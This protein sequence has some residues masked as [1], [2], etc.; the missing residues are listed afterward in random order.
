MFTENL[1]VVYREF[2]CLQRIH[3][4]SYCFIDSHLSCVH[5]VSL[6]SPHSIVSLYPRFFTLLFLKG[7]DAV[8]HFAVIHMLSWKVPCILM[9][10]E[11]SRS[12]AAP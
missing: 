6:M 12:L 2:I 4:N 8:D 1:H 10:V 7:Q 9:A 5:L 3:M 11:K